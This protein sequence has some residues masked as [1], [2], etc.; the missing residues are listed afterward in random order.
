MTFSRPGTSILCVGV[1]GIV[2]AWA[3]TVHLANTRYD[4]TENYAID[5]PTSIT[6]WK[7][8]PK[9]PE[10]LFLF[11]NPQKHYLLRGSVSQVISDVN[12]TPELTTDTM[13]QF[14]IDRTHENMK[15]WTAERESDVKASNVRF[16]VI[17]RQRKSRVVITAFTVKGNTTLMVSL[18]SD[19]ATPQGKADALND[20]DGYIKHISLNFEDI[21]GG[22]K[23]VT[24][25]KGRLINVQ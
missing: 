16:S 7:V 1:I 24:D 15:D 23:A 25:D 10:S 18:S 5:F 8:L 19:T 11:E 9:S 4:G 14:Y 12:P 20:L 21:G 22:K 3:F 13:A 17:Q 2:G 6:G